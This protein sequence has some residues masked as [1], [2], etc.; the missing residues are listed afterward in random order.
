[1]Y[2]VHYTIN[3]YFLFF[4]YYYFFWG[5]WENNSTGF[6]PSYPCNF[7]PFFS[8]TKITQINIRYRFQSQHQMYAYDIF[9]QISRQSHIKY[10]DTDT[11]VSSFFVQERGR[12]RLN[13]F[14][15]WSFLSYVF[16]GAFSIF[17]FSLFWDFTSHKY[18]FLF[19]LFIYLRL[20]CI[21]EDAGSLV[22][23]HY[24]LLHATSTSQ[25]SVLCVH[26]Q[27]TLYRFLFITTFSMLPLL[28]KVVYSL[29]MCSLLLVW[30]G[31]CSLPPSPCY[32]Y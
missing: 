24:H 18:F 10:Q 12:G 30:A 31:S 4:F 11:L 6:N 14:F 19:C 32:R 27:C 7:S 1:M 13:N 25:G 28:A 23:V 17:L 5:S 20:V 16:I 2:I 22:P 29:F 9:K 8:G 3:T 21:H 15:Y 26:V